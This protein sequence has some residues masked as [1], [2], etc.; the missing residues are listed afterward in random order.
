MRSLDGRPSPLRRT[1]RASPGCAT[2]GRDRDGTRCRA[3]SPGAV[4][5]A[6]TGAGCRAGRLPTTP[7]RPA[8]L[9]WRPGPGAGGVRRCPSA[10]AGCGRRRARSHSHRR[11]TTAQPR[12]RIA[13]RR[14]SEW[15]VPTGRGRPRGRTWV[16]VCSAG[17][18]V[19]PSARALVLPRARCCGHDPVTGSWAAFTRSARRSRRPPWRRRAAAR[20]RGRARRPGP[21]RPPG[22]RPGRRS[23]ARRG[24]G[25]PRD[26][27][28]G[29]PA[30]WR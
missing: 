12:R 6:P 1:R 8:R 2:A 29:R 30:R 4:Q 9:G 23:R 17:A 24:G 15:P 11:S 7:S 16:A 10:P 27:G 14:R 18:L 21:P 3:R 5:L 28:P 19:S 13:R 20:H 26:R 25:P 22:C